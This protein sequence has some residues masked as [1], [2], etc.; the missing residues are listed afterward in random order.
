M[1]SLLMIKKILPRRA[2][3]FIMAIAFVATSLGVS[4]SAMAAV[5]YLPAPGT[6]VGAST[7][8]SPVALKGLQFDAQDP[9]KLS[10]ILDEG[11]TA[12]TDSQLKEQ[13]TILVRYFLAALTTP[14]KDMWVNL[15]PY[16]K[17]RVVPDSFA[18]TDLGN[19]MLG[20]DY[21]LK[22]LSASLTHP[23]TDL[24][25]K[26]WNNIQSTGGSRT[27]PT[28]AFNKVWI[29][30][31]ITQV[32]ESGNQVFIAKS[33]LKVSTES[34]YVAM[35]NSKLSIKND[36]VSSARNSDNL[37]LEQDAFKTHILPAITK[38]VNEG[39]NFAQFRQ[40]HSAIVLAIWFKNRLKDSIYQQ[41]YID[42]GKFNGINADDPAIKE[43][44]S[45]SM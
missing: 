22:Q 20:Q 1:F 10:F 15:S 23:D 7:V 4:P 41:L 21:I 28:N 16:E 25:K 30:P 17:D 6:M 24:G 42:K 36:G 27:A 35:Q 43:K 2:V 18:A 14:G 33:T 11:D 39:K 40:M 44:I 31:D 32:Y 45:S 37:K 5:P 13:T 38:E 26:Y 9:F 3:C 19:D 12:L 29:S 8:F 34:D